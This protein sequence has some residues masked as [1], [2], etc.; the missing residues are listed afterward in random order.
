MLGLLLCEK[1][2]EK[3]SQKFFQNCCIAFYKLSNPFGDN[4]HKFFQN[5]GPWP[6]PLA[7]PFPLHLLLMFFIFT[8]GVKRN[9]LKMSRTAPSQL[10]GPK[11]G[12]PKAAVKN[13]KKRMEWMLAG[14]GLNKGM[15]FLTGWPYI[16]L[17][18]ALGG[19]IPFHFHPHTALNMDKFVWNIAYWELLQFFMPANAL[20]KG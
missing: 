14:R 18:L 20:L 1:K 19:S 2:N 4:T 15:E 9:K 16:G 6:I 7:F 11:V 17:K 8:F 13:G 10:F 5:S 12:G 3:D